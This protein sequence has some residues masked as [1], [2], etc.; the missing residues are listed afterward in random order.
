MDFCEIAQR[1]DQRFEA[2]IHGVGGN[3][4]NAALVR[5]IQSK[6]PPMGAWQA[7]LGALPSVPRLLYRCLSGPLGPVRAAPPAR[8]GPRAC[9]CAKEPGWFSPQK[10]P[11]GLA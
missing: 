11:T 4:F 3:L 5:C 9:L 10:T 1:A 2:L 7:R 8:N 6:S